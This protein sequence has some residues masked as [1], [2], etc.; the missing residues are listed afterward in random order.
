MCYT[1]S[2]YWLIC[3]SSWYNIYI[4]FY[5]L[6]ECT[7]QMMTY[8]CEKYC[9]QSSRTHIYICICMQVT[10]NIVCKLRNGIQLLLH[11]LMEL[12]PLFSMCCVL[13]RRCIPAACGA[14]LWT[15]WTR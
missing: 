5:L 8:Y 4:T 1:T 13:M 12:F 15:S 11:F 6:Q 9:V 10:A 2:A 3:N 7:L 14:H